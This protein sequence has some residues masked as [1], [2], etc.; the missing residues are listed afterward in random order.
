MTLLY[1]LDYHVILVTVVVHLMLH[2][3]RLLTAFLHWQLPWLLL[4]PRL[5]PQR[6]GV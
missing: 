5:I 2:L 1:I 4:R 6:G 3:D